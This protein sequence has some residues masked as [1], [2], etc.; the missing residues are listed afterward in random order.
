MSS[1]EGILILCIY[2]LY[3]FVPLVVLSFI[4]E[5]IVPH[6]PAPIKDFIGGILYL[7]LK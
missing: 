5:V 7:I 1:I 2:L 6:L 3:I 4:F